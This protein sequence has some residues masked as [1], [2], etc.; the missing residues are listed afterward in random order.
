MERERHARAGR[1]RGDAED[2]VEG[3]RVRVREDAGEDGDGVAEGRGAEGGEV[4]ER[5]LARSGWEGGTPARRARAWSCL[6]AARDGEARWR[7][8]SATQWRSAGCADGVRPPAASSMRR[9]RLR[10]AS[11]GKARGAGP[12]SRLQFKLL[13]ATP[14]A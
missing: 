9:A 5:C 14:I 8:R 10:A 11:E 2:G 3:E 4:E 13:W 6:A 7:R 1:G 12:S